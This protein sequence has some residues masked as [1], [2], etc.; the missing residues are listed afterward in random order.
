MSKLTGVPTGPPGFPPFQPSHAELSALSLTIRASIT[1][2]ETAKTAQEK[3]A[4]LQKIQVTSTKL[5]RVTTSIQQQFMQLNFG[6]NVNVAIRIG[7]EMGLSVDRTPKIRRAIHART[8]SVFE[9][10]Q[11]SD[12]SPS[13]LPC[14]SHTS[15]SRF[16]SLPPAEAST[17]HTFDNMLHAQVNSANRYYTKNGFET[18][19]DAKN[20]PFSFANGKENMGIFDILEEQPER[21]KVFNSA[22]AVHSTIG[23]KDI[24]KCYPFDNLEPNNDGVVL[25]D[26][27]GGK[28]HVIN[29]IRTVYPQI[30]G[31]MVLEDMQV[32]LDGGTVVPEDVT[33][34]PYDFFKQQQPIEGILLQFPTHSKRLTHIPRLQLLP[35]INTPRL[36]RRLLHP[37]TR[38]LRISHAQFPFVPPLD[39]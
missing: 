19:D 35:Q 23:L 21:M 2:Y 31:S 29:E 25:V 39:L 26:V 9:I 15:Y 8:L 28:G 5:S 37:N 18:P 13:E 3:T 16:L 27:G 14:Y 30:K 6:P 36:T 33:K 34:Q 11:E 20:S 32:V 38:Q 24:I 17:R 4:A 7:V 1:E 12:S 22:M 10:L